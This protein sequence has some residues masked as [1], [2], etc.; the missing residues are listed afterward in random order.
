MKKTFFLSVVLFT[1]FIGCSN[2]NE[3]VYYKKAKEF[4]DAK[5]YPS[6]LVEYQKIV[7]EFPDGKHYKEA[8]LQTGQLNQGNM[9]KQVSK[10][11]ALEKAVE[12]YKLY[13]EKYPNDPKAEQ[14]LFMTGFVLANELN[15]TDEAKEVYSKFLELYPNSEM[16]QSAKSEIETLGLSPDEILKLKAEK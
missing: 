16:A 11:E 6:A 12:I 14:T 8:L 13:F 5:N 2:Q 1:F 9:N 3:D 10:K 7:D 4:I 15:R